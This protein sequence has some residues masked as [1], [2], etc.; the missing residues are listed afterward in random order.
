MTVEYTY[1]TG[2][3]TGVLLIAV[4]GHIGYAAVLL[5]N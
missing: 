2:T 5:V 1:G 4:P 3:G